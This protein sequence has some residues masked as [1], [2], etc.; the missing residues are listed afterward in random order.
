MRDAAFIQLETAML[1]VRSC[2]ALANRPGFEGSEIQ[3]RP[4]SLF[5]E[6]R[7]DNP[8]L[9]VYVGLAPSSVN[10]KQAVACRS[11][12]QCQGDRG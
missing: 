11:L 12:P 7:A 6:G 5:D 2:G 10:L 4:Y 9:I 3:G 1:F 8:N